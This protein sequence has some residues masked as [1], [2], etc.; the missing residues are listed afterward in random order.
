MNDLFKQ[1]WFLMEC[2]WD[3]DLLTKARIKKEFEQCFLLGQL[4][5]KQRKYSKEGK[6]IIIRR[7]EN[8][9]MVIEVGGQIN[10]NALEK[11]DD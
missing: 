4:S 2:R 3:F 6:E 8:G 10:K 1:F 5:R 11:D 7:A 9:N